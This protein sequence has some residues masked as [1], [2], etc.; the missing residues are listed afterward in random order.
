MNERQTKMPSIRK[1]K[2][3]VSGD[4]T[5]D[6]FTLFEPS[7][8]LNASESPKN[9]QLEKQVK[10]FVLPGGS[11]LLAE[12]IKACCADDATVLTCA[13][14]AS[15]ELYKIPPVRFVYSHADLAE[16]KQ[17][18][19]S[20]PGTQTCLRVGRYHGFSGPDS[21]GVDTAA[22]EGDDGT[23]DVV[24]LDDAGNGFRE[25]HNK[26]NW[27]ESL[28]KGNEPFII[29]KHRK[30]LFSGEAAGNLFEYIT[31]NHANRT[32]CILEAD[33]L[34][35]YGV[36]V[37]R[38][39]SW[40]KTVDDFLKLLQTSDV[41]N[42]VLTLSCVMIRF[43]REGAIVMLSGE[44][45]PTALWLCYSSEYREEGIPKHYAGTMNGNGC[46]F[47]A[48][49]VAYLTKHYEDF[50]KKSDESISDTMFVEAAK[51]GIR[52]ALEHHYYGFDN[53]DTRLDYG[54][55]DAKKQTTK[56]KIHTNEVE[57]EK[58]KQQVYNLFISKEIRN[59]SLSGDSWSIAQICAGSGVEDAALDWVRTG[60]SGSFG[61]IPVATFGLVNMVDRTEI[62]SAS[63]V[64]ILLDNYL[65][66][67]G[68]H[69]PLTIA[70]FGQP[71]SGKSFGIKQIATALSDNIVTEGLLLNLSE[72]T[73]SDSLTS[74]FHR[75]RE[76]ALTGK[77]PLALFDEFDSPLNGIELGWLKYFLAPMEDGEFRDGDQINALGKAILVFA[78]GTKHT[79]TDF[80]TTYG[81]DHYKMVKAPDFISRLKGYIDVCGPNPQMSN[82]E[83][84]V[85]FP[86]I[87]EVQEE[88]SAILR[89]ATVLRGLLKRHDLVDKNSGMACVDVPLLRT[90]LRIRKYK[91][92]VRSMDTILKMSIVKNNAALGPSSL[93]PDHLL[94]MHVDAEDFNLTLLFV[95]MRDTMARFVHL[96]YKMDSKDRPLSKK[97]YD[98]LDDEIKNDNKRIFDTI[99]KK[100]SAIRC[101]IV[102]KSMVEDQQFNFNEEE[103]NLLARM[104]H[105]RWCR[106]KEAN[107][108][109][110]GDSRDDNKKIH[111][112]LTS[113][114]NLSTD[115]KDQ[116]RKMIN[117]IPD[118]LSKGGL[119]I[120]RNQ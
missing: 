49:V 79:Y 1:L 29:Y 82:E 46:A 25:V 112:L 23:A 4:Q 37:S 103:L 77:V 12:M 120:I 118:I 44:K 53:H 83:T 19:V 67:T 36:N 35:D 85:H 33:N 59:L 51:E 54:F 18:H 41:L 60:M 26:K 16:F 70:V 39:I 14:P 45:Q 9:W 50:E 63:S 89:R 32:L 88:R 94:N 15:E 109:R 62:E 115:I 20:S 58:L 8:V 17:N 73:D 52:C 71:G 42:N 5:I 101:K 76:V 22:V 56:K 13:P 91:H 87:G 116:N 102:T 64:E 3:V 48:G 40:E 28:T 98:E 110:Y 74:T 31:S 27:P 47:T 69:K 113:W 95:K 108:W 38:G 106:D 7:P 100:L 61:R 11:L 117:R 90:L 107:G 93:L 99:P 6:R 92:G 114:E 78:G 81:T 111:N 57:L 34:R 72:I 97:Q 96:Y 105:E 68:N 2:I 24:V 80:I 10:S 119:A 55:I 86:Y 75:I 65:A 66:Q 84:N 21:A 104:E 43:G 30:P